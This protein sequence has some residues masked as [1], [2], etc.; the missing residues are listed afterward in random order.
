MRANGF[1]PRILSI[2][3][4]PLV[5]KSNDAGLTGT[6]C[7][8]L[9]RFIVRHCI[10]IV[11]HLLSD[12]WL[13]IFNSLASG[14]TNFHDTLVEAFLVAFVFGLF[15]LD[16][17]FVRLNLHFFN[18]VL[19]AK[20]THAWDVDEGNWVEALNPLELNTHDLAETFFLL[21]IDKHGV[22]VGGVRGDRG[23]DGCA[24][25]HADSGQGQHVD[26]VVGGQRCLDF[27]TNQLRT[28]HIDKRW[29]L[30]INLGH[31][32]MSKMS[33]CTMANHEQIVILHLVDTVVTL[34]QNKAVG[35]TIHSLGTQSTSNKED[36]AT[37]E[38]LHALRKLQH[39]NL[40]AGVLLRCDTFA[41]AT[42]V[43]STGLSFRFRKD[44]VALAKL[45]LVIGLKMAELPAD[46][47][48]VVWVDRRGDETASPIRVDAELLQI[49]LTKGWEEL[50]PVVWIG[51]LWNL[52]LRNFELHQYFVL[53]E[54]R[55]DIVLGGLLQERGSG[56]VASCLSRCNFTLQTNGSGRDWHTSAMEAEWEKCALT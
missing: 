49:C 19:G 10:T 54:G 22:V 2:A 16:S 44:R 51:E 5:A 37:V 47:L 36:I 41:T 31:F 46:K 32:L 35:L 11:V 50:E 38:L 7:H 24:L 30:I 56:L 13:S 48:V 43:I 23:H 18:S 14:D 29:V 8:F 15:K 25:S 12:D 17:V 6:S 21:Q 33:C 9:L 39:T 27:L 3:E 4:E 20:V 28:L 26:E 52:G 55:L 53:G 45:D 1:L 40:N 42:V 34:W